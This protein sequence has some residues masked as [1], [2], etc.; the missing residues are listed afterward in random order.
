[1]ADGQKKPI[2]SVKVGDEVLAFD[3]KTKTLKK[4]KVKEFFQH[5]AVEYLVVNGTLKVTSNHPVYSEGKW[6]EIGTLKIGDKLLN[7]DG[8]PNPIVSMKKIQANVKVFNL[9]VNP[10]HTYIA[11]GIVVHNKTKPATELP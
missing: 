10:Y 7:S 1:M 5:D 9:E 2:E 11:N 8:T 4:D 6:V 3:E